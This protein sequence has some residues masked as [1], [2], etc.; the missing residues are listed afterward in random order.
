MLSLPSFFIY[1][2]LL[3]GLFLAVVWIVNWWVRYKT[4][5][6]DSF[7]VQKVYTGKRLFYLYMKC[8]VIVLAVASL[9]WWVEMDFL[10][11]L[12]ILFLAGLA[13]LGIVNGE[14]LAEVKLLQSQSENMMLRSQLNPHFLYNTLNNIDA[15]LWLDPEKASLAINNLSGLMRYITYSTKQDQVSV[16]EEVKHLGLLVEVQ[17]LRMPLPES[18]VFRTSIDNPQSMIAPLLLLP[19]M[20]NCFK[21]CGDLNQEG[22][23]Q[24][25]IEIR[26]GVL[27]FESSNNLPDRKE[28]PQPI[29]PNSVRRKGIGMKVL[30]KR[31]SLLYHDAYTFEHGIQGNRYH[32]H[33]QVRLVE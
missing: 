19:L 31:L 17:R 32:T 4:W 28:E 6:D 20:E 16:E 14:D 30:Q 9:F 10:M 11:M 26:D 33:L 24:L 21:H 15:L 12:L 18:L 23:V 3:L 8:W 5:H 1:L 25:S 7:V 29:T 13:F 27:T 2:F 22:A